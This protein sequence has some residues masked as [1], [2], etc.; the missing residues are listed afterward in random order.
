MLALL[1]DNY[2][3]IKHIHMLCV[4]LSLS[5]FTLR[6]AWGFTGSQL[7]SKPWVKISPHIVDT[8]L[9]LSAIALAAVYTQNLSMPLP[10]WIQAKIIGLV[11]YITFGILMFRASKNTAQRMAYFTLASLSFLYIL[12]VAF[13]KQALPL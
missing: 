10:A 1:Q 7:L 5:F 3:A 12:A 2:M 9:L 11:F 8:V 6:A 4:V 13:S